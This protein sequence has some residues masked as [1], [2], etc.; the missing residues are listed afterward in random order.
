MPYYVV[1]GDVPKVYEIGIL[2]PFSV[3]ISE[4]KVRKYGTDLSFE[5]LILRYA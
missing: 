4:G 3:I 2:T 5:E 1:N